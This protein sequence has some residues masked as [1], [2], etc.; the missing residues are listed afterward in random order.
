M[1]VKIVTGLSE[2]SAETAEWF[3]AMSRMNFYEAA[4]SLYDYMNMEQVIQEKEL[5]QMD[6]PELLSLKFVMQLIND[7]DILSPRSL[8]RH[9]DREQIVRDAKRFL[10][11]Y[12]KKTSC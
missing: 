11:Y 7:P 12:K 1:V 3:P 9:Q 5:S 6:I 2:L 4:I 10:R 8:S